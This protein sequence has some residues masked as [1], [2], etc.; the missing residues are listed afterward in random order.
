M[1][2]AQD[3][4]SLAP[5]LGRVEQHTYG[6]MP[7]AVVEKVFEHLHTAHE[8]LARVVGCRHP[9]QAGL[10]PPDPGKDPPESGVRLQ[11]AIL[12]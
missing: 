8:S 9:S 11:A 1:T 3:D 4:P 5:W 7:V 12:R 2:A 10:D 6:S